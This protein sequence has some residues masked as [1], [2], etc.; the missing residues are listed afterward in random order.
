MLFPVREASRVLPVPYPLSPR[1]LPAS[2]PALTAATAITAR[3]AG[4]GAAE[5]GRR[6]GTPCRHERDA[7]AAGS[8]PPPASAAN[9]LRKNVIMGFLGG[10]AAPPIR[11]GSPA[12]VESAEVGL[13]N[14]CIYS[15]V[16]AEARRKSSSSSTK[17]TVF[18]MPSPGRLRT[19]RPRSAPLR[20]TSR[21]N[22]PRCP[23]ISP[24]PGQGRSVSRS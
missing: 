9:S 21:Q 4:I 15:S 22:R 14:P 13:S 3:R 7:R 2:H 19:P 18:V 1:H 24:A 23:G 5:P 16:A 6:G 20:P 8:R 17:R 12:S 10:C 11:Q